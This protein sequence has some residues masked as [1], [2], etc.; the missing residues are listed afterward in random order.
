MGD[1]TAEKDAVAAFK[2]RERLEWELRQEHPSWSSRRVR[3]AVD[4]VLGS[5]QRAV[6][7]PARVA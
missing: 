6:S 3:R 4:R 7:K 2:E 5:R 1:Q